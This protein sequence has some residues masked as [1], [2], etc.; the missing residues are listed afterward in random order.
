MDAIAG[1]IDMQKRHLDIMENIPVLRQHMD[2]GG[3]HFFRL[4]RAKMNTVILHINQNL[5]EDPYWAELA[6]QLDFRIAL[7]HAIDRQ[8]IIDVV[9]AGQSEPWQTAPLAN[10]PFYNEKL[11]KQ[12]TE[13]DPDKANEML[14]EF[15]PN[16]DADGFRL[17]EDNGERLSIV[18]E[19]AAEFKRDWADSLEIISEQWKRVGLELK[20]KTHE[21]AFYQGQRHEL[22]LCMIS[23]WEGDIS[24][25]GVGQL[26]RGNATHVKWTQWLESGG[27]TGEEPPE[28]YKQMQALEDELKMTVDFEKQKELIAQIQELYP[29]TRIGVCTIPPGFGVVKNNF[30]NVSPLIPDMWIGATVALDNPSQYW[31]GQA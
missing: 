21:R 24:Y 4:Q 30:H 26:I 31:I 25:W 15:L 29:F 20:I 9:Y 2:D 19:T 22:G 7:S 14:D 27:T 13:Y 3:Y 11:A 5:D 28:V 12:Y 8:E 6:Q 18:A 23:V 1:E 10:S 16:K 17:R